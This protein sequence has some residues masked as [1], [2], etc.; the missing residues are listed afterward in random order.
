V[1]TL[2]LISVVLNVCIATTV[3][4][5]AQ[6]FATLL[7]FAGADGLA[8]YAGLVQGT[9]GN[10]YGTTQNG[11]TNGSG[12]VFKITP[13]GKLTTLYNFCSQ[14]LC[15]DG[16]YPEGTLVQATNGKLYGT[17]YYGGFS[18]SNCQPGCGTVFEITAAGEL[19]TLYIFCKQS[20][21]SDGAR[22]MAGLIQANNGN[23]YGTAAQGGA[24]SSGTV[25]R[26]TPEG[27]L[28][29]LYSFCVLSGC[30][31]GSAPLGGLIQARDGNFYGTTCCGG[32]NGVSGTVFRITPN[33]KLTTLHSFD[34]FDGELPF[35]GLVE[36]TDGNFYGTTYQGG[37]Y[38]GT[39]FKITPAGQLTTLASF[40]PEPHL[41]CPNGAFPNAGLVQGTDGNFYGTTTYFIGSKTLATVFK[42]SFKGK[43]IPLHKFNGADGDL[44]YAG[45]IQATNGNFYG[46]T[47]GGGSRGDGTVFGL[48]VGLGPFVEIRPMSGKAG[49]S[50]IVLGNNL[51]DTT[52]VAF[53]GT[54]ATFTVISNT[55]IRATVPLGATTG[56]VSVTTL[57]GTLSS[58]VFFR[59][60]P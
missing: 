21:C 26:I 55:E 56:S 40:C 46:T 16:S 29:T 27:T 51:R 18:D 15:T 5:S 39:V 22:P 41:G 60:R 14:A 45:L 58:N 52:S 54:S 30:A 12:T 43:F 4:S 2:R 32:S 35:A 34:G 24:N 37:M 19:T 17:T 20:A 47:Y 25:F 38:Y 10:F 50:V 3:S 36:A 42:V 53:N 7:N 59:V 44:P 48:E 57:A 28:T 6:T 11:G 23:L 49:T 33:G 13:E 31:D 1:R 9:N 8:P